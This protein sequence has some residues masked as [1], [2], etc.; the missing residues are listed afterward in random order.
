VFRNIPQYDLTTNA[1][2][3]NDV[4]VSR[5]ELEA[6]Y[7]FRSFQQQL[8]THINYLLYSENLA[9]INKNKVQ[10]HNNPGRFKTVLD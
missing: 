2:S 4:W 3:S 5:T 10:L 1:T 6:Q 8:Q 9:K 7:I